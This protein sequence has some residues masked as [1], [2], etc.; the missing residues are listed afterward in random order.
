MK[1]KTI[2]IGFLLQYVT[3]IAAPPAHQASTDRIAALEA[4]IEALEKQLAP[5][6]QKQE[7]LN[8]ARK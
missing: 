1:T 8:Q 7:R 2:I 4:R 6:L 5:L 3:A